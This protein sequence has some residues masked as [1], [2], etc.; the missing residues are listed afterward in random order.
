[1]VQLMIRMLLLFLLWLVGATVDSTPQIWS[2]IGIDLMSDARDGSQADAAQLAYHY[3]EVGDRLW[4]RIGLYGK[5]AATTL[6][7]TIAVDA[8]GSEAHKTRWPGQN[9]EFR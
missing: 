2:V 3:D 4:F 8:G 9:A 1:M 7:V 5:P 6:A